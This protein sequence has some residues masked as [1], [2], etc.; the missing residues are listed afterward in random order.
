LRSQHAVVVDGTNFLCAL[1][2]QNI[3]A[4]RIVNKLHLAALCDIIQIAVRSR[5]GTARTTGIDFFCSE[6]DIGQRKGPKVSFE[7]LQRL[8]D[9]LR[10]EDAVTVHSVRMRAKSEKEK[11]VDVAVAVKMLELARICETVVLVS[12]DTDQVP[13]LEALKRQGTYIATCGFGDDHPVELRN[14]GFLFIDLS[15]SVGSLF[16]PPGPVSGVSLGSPR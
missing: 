10:L 5:F 14:L 8:L 16:Q 4:E 1:L 12:D 13:A 11:G 3:D 2:R 9:R 15:G 6:R 7:Q